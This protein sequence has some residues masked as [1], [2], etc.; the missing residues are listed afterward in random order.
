MKQLLLFSVLLF[1]TQHMHA[2]TLVAQA[3]QGDWG[4]VDTKGAFIIEPIYK[5]CFPF[6]ASGLAPVLDPGNKNAMF[7]DLKGAPVPTEV[8]DFDLKTGFFGVGAEGFS[9]GMIPVRIKKKWGFMNQQG[10]LVVEAKYDNVSGFREGHAVAVSRKQ[11]FILNKDG[12]ETAVDANVSELRSFEGGLAPFVG[13]D[14]L[15]GFMDEQGNTVIP[16]QFQSVG[17]FSGPLAWAKDETGKLGYIDRKG[18]WVITPQFDAGHDFDPNTGLARVKTSDGLAFV[19]RSGKLLEIPE[20]ESLGDFSE[21]LA[22]AKK[23]GQFGFVDKTGKWVIEPQFESVRDFRNGFA[24]ARSDGK[25]GF[26]D[27]NG[28]WVI[29]PQFDGV[30]DFELVK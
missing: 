4:Y 14:K 12:K 3:K 2:Q 30:R 25:W 28:K 1:T 19:D 16:A 5:T 10:K 20:H 8:K 15:L 9:S 29:Q 7:I 11:W 23:G 27:K 17:Y 24:S 13:N 18:V 6:S 26:I 21:G 22:E